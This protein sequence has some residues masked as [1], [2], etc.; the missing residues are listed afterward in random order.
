MICE[1]SLYILALH[2]QGLNTRGVV[3]MC[4]VSIFLPAWRMPISQQAV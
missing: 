2:W 3:E 4:L 1:I